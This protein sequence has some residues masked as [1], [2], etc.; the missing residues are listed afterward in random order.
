MYLVSQR[1]SLGLGE[2]DEDETEKLDGREAKQKA[3][4]AEGRV[5]MCLK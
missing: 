5:E 2:E 1:K 3:E 4:A